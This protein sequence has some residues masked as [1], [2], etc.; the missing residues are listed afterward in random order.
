MSQAGIIS[1]TSGPVPPSVPTQFTT[2]SGTAIPAANNLNVFGGVGATTSG[3]GSTITITVK[4]DGF[5][6]SE[7][8]LSFSAAVQNGYFCTAALTV[9]LPITAGLVIGNSIIIYVDTVIATDQ[10]IVQASPGQ[11]I[12]VG[13]NISAIAGT[14]TSPQNFIGGQLELVYKP[15]DATWHTINSMGSWA[16]V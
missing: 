16:V 1:T 6:W 4:N 12:Q 8:A 5:A 3:S 15:S 11:K 9:T 7:Q 10:V 2:D 13:Q 14:A